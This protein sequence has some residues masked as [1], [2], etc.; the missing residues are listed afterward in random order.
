MVAAGDDVTLPCR[1]EPQ[2]DVAGETV[3]WSKPDLQPDPRDLLSRVEYVH[4]YRDTHEV[5][6]MK[7]SSYVRRTSL[8]ADGLRRGNI[9]LKIIN[10]TLADKGRYKCYIPKLQHSQV[11]SS[12]V[13]L[14]VCEL[15]S[16]FINMNIFKTTWV[17]L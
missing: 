10:V 8:F 15:N 3:E 9:S 11:Q 17:I 1:V 2:L 12:I 14:V 16:Y 5:P 7:M 13:H 4:V 6:D